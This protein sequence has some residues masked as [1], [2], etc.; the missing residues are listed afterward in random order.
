MLTPC[1]VSPLP[2]RC[3]WAK[4][5]DLDGVRYLLRYLNISCAKDA[6]TIVHQYFDN[7]ALLPK[8]RLAFKELPG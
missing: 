4:F 5:H 3:A 2:S 8:T 7:S 6:M 1:Q